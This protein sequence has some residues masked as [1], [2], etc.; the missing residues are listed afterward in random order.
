MRIAF[1]ILSHRAPEQLLRLLATLRRELPDAPIVVHH[2]MFREGLTASALDPIGNVKLL[3]TD[4]PT[5]WGDFSI[6]DACWRSMSWMIEHLEF[7]WV[8]ML[9]AQDYP[10][11]PLSTLGDY[12]AD[13]GADALLRSTP[14]NRLSNAA[15]RRDRRRR[16]LYQYKPT[17]I[18]LH[19]DPLFD[20]LRY[21][22]RKSTGRLIDVIN[23]LQPYF[24]IYRMPDR[25]PY[26]FG[27]RAN[28]SPFTENDPCWYG[29]MW[30]SLSYRAAKF[31]VSCTRERPDYVDYY[32]RT[33]IPDESATTTLLCNAT[34][35]RIEQCELH[36]T[37]WTHSKT[38]HPDTFT[39]D[40]LHELM[41]VP[42][43]FARKFD[44]AKDSKILDELDEMLAKSCATRMA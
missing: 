20:E 31:V 3:T 28:S 17:K 32:R 24:K 35:L 9:S 25:L 14:I 39:V 30:L 10:I 5:A 1:L 8:V 37:R 13:T 33:I 41:S 7:D 34:D 36:H 26:R 40:D 42:E 15:D 16:Y 29:S 38:G 44:I 11:K 18:T 43:Y 6:V 22:M 21:G 27:W 2:D 23:I 4:K 12:L 19:R